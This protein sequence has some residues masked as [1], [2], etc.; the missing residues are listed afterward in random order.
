MFKKKNISL[1]LVL[2][3]IFTLSNISVYANEADNLKGNETKITILSTSDIHGRIYP[4]DYATDSVDDDAGL[5]KIATLIKQERAKNENNILVDCG[6]LIQDNSIELF[7]DKKPNPMIEA[8]NILE[9]DAF[10][11]GNHEFNYEKSFLENNIKSFNKAVLSANIYKDDGSRFVKPYEIIEKD[12]VKVAI[13]GLIAPHV[14]KWEASSPSHFE[15]LKFEDPLKE[16]KKAVKEL[17]GKYDILVGAFHIGADGEHG[18]VGT[19]EIAKQVPEFDIIF[20][21]HAHSLYSD[22]KVNDTLVIEPG[23]YG[24]ALAKADIIVEKEN[25]EYKVKSVEASNL[26]T[27]KIEADKDFLEKFKFVHEGSVKDANLVV[28]KIES[29]FIA[30]PDY[31]TGEDKITTMPTAQ[32]QDSAVIDFINEV[33]MYYAKSDISSAALFNF[34]SNLKKGDFKKK[35]VAY[36]YKYPNTLVGTKITGENLK[37]YMEWSANY[38]NKFN[39]GDLTISFNKDIRGYNYDMFS[40]VDYKIDISKDNGQRIV[41]LKI[42]GKDIEDDK[43]Y[44]IAINNYR[45]GT[46]MSLN[47]VKAQDKYFDSYE[48][49][50]DNGRIRSLIV[51]Y[52][53]EVKNGVIKPTVDNNWELIGFDIDEKLKEE[54]YELI[55]EGKLLIPTS[56]DGRTK[57]IKSIRKEDLE[58]IKTAA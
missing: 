26:S 22:K 23:K 36:I 45:F 13:V 42:N 46:L 43:I 57:N 51:K 54:A 14:P 25:N 18:S 15:G 27:K 50:Q 30:R 35:D 31:I 39:E 3:L 1:L 4:H 37:K 5:A 21:G 52:V 28:G 33:Q 19:L 48:V 12:G 10:V 58:N 44:K 34:G 38:Y 41:D 56:E 2:M 53:K 17:E 40:G 11:L 8:L 29:D 20:C 7:M 47:L 9:Y 24:Q 49:M 55:K 16:A 6:D 32:L